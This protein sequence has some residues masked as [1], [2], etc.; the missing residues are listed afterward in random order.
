MS[1]SAAL[2]CNGYAPKKSIIQ[3]I[4]SKYRTDIICVDGGLNYIY[5][6]KIIPKILI[7]DLDSADKK[8]LTQCAKSKNIN[9]IKISRQT[10]TDLE[11]ALKFCTKQKYK[12]VFILGFSG[13]RFDHTLSN[14][15]NAIKFA[16]KFQIILID[17]YSALQLITGVNRFHSY[18]GEVLSLLAFSGRTLITTKN[19]KYPLKKSSLMIGVRESTSNSSISDTFEV[20][21][22][23]GYA[24]L[25]RHVENFLKYD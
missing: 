8:I 16:K 2:F 3:K 5:K 17:N 9:V 4:E 15:S 25:T 21:V 23:N 10:D 1:K 7:G 22:E 11:K 13:N 12:K 24:L 19:L 20:T 18:K 6:Y 14:I